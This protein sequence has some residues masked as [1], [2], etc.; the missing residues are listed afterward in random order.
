LKEDLSPLTSI[1]SSLM[2][3]S[4]CSVLKIKVYSWISDEV[5]VSVD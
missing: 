1:P 2:K 3:R 5:V 4:H